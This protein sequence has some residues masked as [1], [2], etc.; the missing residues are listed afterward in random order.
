MTSKNPPK[1]DKWVAIIGDWFIQRGTPYTQRSVQAIIEGLPPDRTIVT[2]Y[3]P[4]GTPR[5]VIDTAIALRRELLVGTPTLETLTETPTGSDAYLR[6]LIDRALLPDAHVY[7]HALNTRPPRITPKTM[8]QALH[9]ILRLPEVG[10]V[11]LV[12]GVRPIPG[13]SKHIYD[14]ILEH[15]PGRYQMYG[16]LHPWTS[17]ESYAPF[18]LLEAGATPF[19]PDRSA[20]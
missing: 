5:L 3:S 17:A 1:P 7:V 6:G 4:H 16:V 18:K 15:H 8:L 19:H 12:D 9:A 20:L 14:L 2:P 13:T 10:H 11:I